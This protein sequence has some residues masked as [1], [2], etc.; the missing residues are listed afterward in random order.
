MEQILHCRQILTD[1]EW[2]LDVMNID[3]EDDDL[4]EELFDTVLKW[5]KRES[6][7]ISITRIN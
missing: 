6:K 4:T 3:S 2:K 7:I 5:T 1:T